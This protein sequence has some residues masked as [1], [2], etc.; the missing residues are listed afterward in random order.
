M[1]TAAIERLDG[2]L[3]A[4]SKKLKEVARVADIHTTLLVNGVLVVR[5]DVNGDCG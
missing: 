5:G 2:E 4:K 1:Q 3:A